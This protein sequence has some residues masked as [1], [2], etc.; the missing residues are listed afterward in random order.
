MNRRHLYVL[1]ALLAIVGTGLTFYRIFSLGFP[2]TPG[3]MTETWQ[4]E[5]QLRFDATGGPVKATLMLPQHGSGLTLVDQSF[6][7]P[8]YGFVTSSPDDNRHVEFSTRNADGV[9]AL[10]YN[11]LVHRARTRGVRDALPEPAVQRSSYRDAE[12]A[13]ADAIMQDAQARSA[14]LRGF[15]RLVAGRLQAPEENGPASLL[16]GRHPT[17]RRVAEVMVDILGHA[18]V[19]ARTVHGL[20]LGPDRRDARFAHWIEI[21]EDDEWIAFD[22]ER[23]EFAAPKDHLPWWRGEE[24]FVAVSGGNDVQATLGVRQAFE[25]AL[26]TA[27]TTGSAARRQ[28]LDFSVFGLPQHTQEVYHMLFTVPIGVFLLVVLRNI[29]GLK[30]FGTFMPVL[31]ALAFR[32]TGLGAGL[33]LFALV[34]AGGMVVRFYLERLKLLLVPRLASVV[35]VVVLLM[36]ALSILSHKLGID[37]G[38]SVALFPIVILTMTIERMTL[39]WEERG[40]R[41]AFT[42]AIGSVL[43]AILCYLVMNLPTVGYFVFVFPESLLIVLAMTLLLGR[44]AGYRLVELPRFRVLAPLRPPAGPGG[45]ATA[46][47][48]AVPRDD[49]S[50]R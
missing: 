50:G 28:L 20:P 33:V 3:E 11:V 44:Y 19:P 25:F 42:Q 5:V 14:D 2:P 10:Y 30:T 46:A 15:V 22:Q 4:I 38:L 13:A 36:A 34:L 40:P 31:I 41:E 17:S 49:L 27:L 12:L 43:V 1:C 9:Q 21:F 7:A 8:G 48:N 24:P 45:Y 16:L 37:R 29:I 23:R 39:V 47:R 6:V 26:Q 35:I 32:Q 18:N